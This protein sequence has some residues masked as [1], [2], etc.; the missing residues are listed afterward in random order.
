MVSKARPR[1]RDSSSKLGDTQALNHL[2]PLGQQ[3][4]SL[5]R[6]YSLPSVVFCW[7][8]WNLPY[9]CTIQGSAKDFRGV[10][11][12]RLGLSALCSLFLIR[13]LPSVSRSSGRLKPKQLQFLTYVLATLR[14]WTKFG[15]QGEKPWYVTSSILFLQGLNPFSFCWIFV[16]LKGPQIIV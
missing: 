1:W 15:P 3:L 10:C 8:H 14:C 16:A 4:I 9:T 5:L 7:S 2:P 13:F 12:Q 11:T 6:F